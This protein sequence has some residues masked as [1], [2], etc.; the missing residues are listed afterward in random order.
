MGVLNVNQLGYRLSEKFG[1]HEVSLQAEQGER[2]SIIGP[3]G[4]GKSTLLKIMARLMTPHQ[5]SVM[6]NGRDIAKMKGRDAARMLSMLTQIQ[7]DLSEMTVRD[8]VQYGR[9]PYRS[10]LAGSS[11]ADQTIVEWAI[12]ET[13]LAQLADRQLDSLSGGERQRA[14]IAMALAQ[15]PKVLLLDEPTT[16]LDIA[17]Q[18][19][20]LEL[21]N[22]LNEQLNMT[23]IMVLHDMNQ[24]AQYSDRMIV[25]QDGRIVQS[26][27]PNEV[28]TAEMFEQ[29]FRIRVRIHQEQT[30]PYI[31]PIA[32]S[33]V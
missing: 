31:F 25:M 14:W 29:V 2:I 10:L 28:M 23:I 11:E 24:A 27:T 1:L 26:G 20:V 22:R 32:V 17:H 8:L 21:M 4:S 15:K 13:R 19:E 33:S 12:H 6:L 9:H 5:G 7:P 3:N 16:Y 18:L 30:R